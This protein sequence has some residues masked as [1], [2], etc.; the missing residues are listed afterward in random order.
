MGAHVKMLK[1]QI[2]SQARSSNFCQPGHF[3]SQPENPREHVNTI[4]LRS[5]R[6]MPKVEH[7]IK[8]TKAEP[9]QLP[10]EGE[11]P[12][13]NELDQD[14]KKTKN[15]FYLSHKGWVMGYLTNSFKK[16]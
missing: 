14:P 5:R 1:Y 15:L 13:I 9:D 16:F 4:T 2:A 11:K 10:K 7:K 3:P 8:E 6:Q 12:N